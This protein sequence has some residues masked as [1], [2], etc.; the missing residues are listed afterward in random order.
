MRTCQGPQLHAARDE[1]VEPRPSVVGEAAGEHGNGVRL[2]AIAEGDEGLLKLVPF[3]RARAVAIKIL[4]GC[5]DTAEEA[6]HCYLMQKISSSLVPH[7]PLIKGSP[8]FLELVET[9]LATAITLSVRDMSQGTKPLW[10]ALV[11]V[12]HFMQ[13]TRC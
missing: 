5:L 1:I 11:E 2:E 13:T 3:H 12:T 9:H 7:L 6:G 4:K 10:H 8:K